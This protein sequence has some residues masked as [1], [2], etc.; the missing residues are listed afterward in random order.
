M[1]AHP[2]I[3]AIIG[4]LPSSHIVASQRCLDESMGSRRSQMIDISQ[5]HSLENQCWLTESNSTQENHGEYRELKIVILKR[6][7]TEILEQEVL[8]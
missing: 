1:P 5:C 8:S 4:V 7:V 3:V 6:R 2:C